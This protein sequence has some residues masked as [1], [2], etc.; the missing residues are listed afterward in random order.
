V[1]GSCLWYAE[2]GER[3]CPDHAADFLK[4]G[5]SVIPPERYAEGIAHS[6]ASAARP[7]GPALPYQGNSTDLTGL[8]AAAAGVAALLSCAG[9]SWAI[10]F[11]AFVLGLMAWL[12]AREAFDASRTRWLAGLGL[13]GGGLFVLIFLG[14]FLV[15]ALCMLFFI[16]ASSSRPGGFPTPMPFFTPTA[17]P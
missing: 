9:L 4:A 12:H 16:A 11:L 17:I 1:C 7:G 5:K 10:P 8:L 2:S 15:T 3:L 13:A 14:F 6:E